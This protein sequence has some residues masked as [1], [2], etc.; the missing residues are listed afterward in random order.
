MEDFSGIVNWENVFKESE[1]FKNQKPFRFGFIREFFHR[2]FYE[3]LYEGYPDLSTFQDGSDLSRSQFSKIWGGFGQ[4][5]IVENID[6]PNF[7]EYWNKFQRYT[8]TKEFIEN[9]RKF[10][11]I[12]VNK[13]KLFHFVSYTKGGFQ[14]PHVHNVGPST[15][16]MFSFFSKGWKKGDPGGTY[17]AKDIDESSI[18]FEPDNLDNTMALFHDSEYSIHGVRYMTKDVERRANCITLEEYSNEKGWSGGNPKKILE[19]RKDDLIEL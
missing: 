11:G 18:L 8:C 16:V 13:R 2:E 4:H 7:N 12:P 5:D 1:S 14:L 9:F 15:L 6:D 17:M 10:S 3:K 19:T